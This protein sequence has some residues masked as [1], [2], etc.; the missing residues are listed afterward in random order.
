MLS[1][2]R[3]KTEKRSTRNQA[4]LNVCW[5]QNVDFHV[6]CVPTTLFVAFTVIMQ[7]SLATP[8]CAS[9][10]FTGP[11]ASPSPI[12]E[13]HLRRRTAFVFVR[14]FLLLVSFAAGFLHGA[15]AKE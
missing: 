12:A 1:S 5:V 2:V 10:S 9:G 11:K 7:S 4:C 15:G 13:G 14:G 3:E 6:R 8:K